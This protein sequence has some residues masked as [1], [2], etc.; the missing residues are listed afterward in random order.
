MRFV[1]MER[2]ECTKELEI[3]KLLVQLWFQ[4]AILAHVYE[5]MWDVS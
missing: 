1:I 5:R 2:G 4:F 3:C